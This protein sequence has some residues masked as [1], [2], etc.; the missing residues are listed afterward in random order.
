VGGAHLQALARLGIGAFHLA[1]PEVFE[2]VNF[3]RQFGATTATVGRS[4]V[5]AVA[6]V[7]RAINPEVH[8]RLFRDGITPANIDEFLNG[9]DAVVDGLEF[10]AIQTRRLLCAACRR[11]GI[12]VIQAGPIG[13]GAA[14]L[15]LMPDGLSFDAHFGIDDSMT[16]AEMLLAHALGH[17]LRHD[18]D[19]TRVDLEKQTGPALASACMLCAAAA[20]TEVLKLR[21]GRGRVL[22]APR[23]LYYDPYHGVAVALRR[24]PSL[25]HSLR[26]RLLRWLS[27]RRFPALRALHEREL[28]E[29]RTFI[30]QRPT[31]NPVCPV[32]R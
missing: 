9:V 24:R 21:C 1:D 31:C 27:F 20:A 16:R 22:A 23:G 11:R 14:V 19:P 4:K 15:V 6:D 30:D 17:A 13:Y 18:I 5:D 25:R 8:L 10:F 28:A 32:P 29:R 7:A 2:I 3:N 12:P 26:G